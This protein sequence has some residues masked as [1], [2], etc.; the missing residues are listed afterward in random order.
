MIISKIMDFS[1]PLNPTIYA[2]IYL[3]LNIYIISLNGKDRQLKER[4]P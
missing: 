2:R 4:V 3:R 1:V